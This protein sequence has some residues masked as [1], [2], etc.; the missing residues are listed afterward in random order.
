MQNPHNNLR[1][2]T[3]SANRLILNN[4]GISP[5]LRNTSSPS[6][7]NPNQPPYAFYQSQ[8]RPIAQPTSPIPWHPLLSQSNTFTPQGLEENVAE[9]IELYNNG[10][11]PFPML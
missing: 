2:D 8:F 5:S 10:T 3:L 11:P 4:L 7:S 6:T 1:L 9:T